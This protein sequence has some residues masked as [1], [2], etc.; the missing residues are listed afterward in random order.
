MGTGDRDTVSRYSPFTTIPEST[1]VSYHRASSTKPDIS[2]FGYT[3]REYAKKQKK[4]RNIPM[5][6][7]QKLHK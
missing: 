4:D 7:A 5:R 6:F 2:F 3:D 1:V